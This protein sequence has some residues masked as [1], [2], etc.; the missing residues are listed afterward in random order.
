MDPTE[1]VCEEC[2]TDTAAPGSSLC[3][4]CL[5]EQRELDRYE[6]DRDER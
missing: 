5:R 6:R 4:Y 1:D 2:L 3:R